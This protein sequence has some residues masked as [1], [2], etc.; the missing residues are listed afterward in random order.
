MT[1]DTNAE[2]FTPS[3]E[4]FWIP[5]VVVYC[6]GTLVFILVHTCTK[7]DNS[8]IDPCWSILFVIPN[9]V[10]LGM[11]GKDNITGRMWFITI[12]VLIWA[13]RLSSYIAIRHTGEDYRYKQLR[14][15]WEKAGTCGY[16]VQA[17]LFVYTM[18]ATFMFVNNSSVLYVNLYSN[19]ESRG[20]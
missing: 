12:P 13:A 10:I 1:A 16:Y 11:R 17:Y 7:R 6:F 14:E 2:P 5:I 18:Q 20:L 9:A 15:G 19:S 8:W 4:Y 3:A